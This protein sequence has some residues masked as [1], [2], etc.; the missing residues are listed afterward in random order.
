MVM[1]DVLCDTPYITVQMYR[2]KE[3]CGVPD[4]VNSTDTVHN[5]SFISISTVVATPASTVV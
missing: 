2:K 4:L 3:M 5:S 1:D